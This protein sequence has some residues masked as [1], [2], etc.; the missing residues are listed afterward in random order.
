MAK[1]RM[2]KGY[3]LVLRGRKISCHRTKGLAK[4]RLAALRKRDGT[5]RGGIRIRQA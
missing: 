5:R 1:K 4:K 2:K 3:C